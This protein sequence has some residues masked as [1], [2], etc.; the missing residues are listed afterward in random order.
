MVNIALLLDLVDSVLNRRKN[1]LLLAAQSA[2]P[3]EQ[4]ESYRKQLLNE[5]GN[6]GFRRELEN[7]LRKWF[8]ERQG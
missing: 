3:A 1:K 4:F 6:S 5:L 7:E 8:K 2:M